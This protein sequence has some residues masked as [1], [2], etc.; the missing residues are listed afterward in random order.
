MFFGKKVII[1]EGGGF[2]TSFT[3][4]VL[5]AFMVYDQFDFDVIV[6]VSGGALAGSYFLSRQFGDYYNTI[7]DY[8]KDPRFV[9]FSKVF[10]EGLLNLNF[11]HEITEQNFP[12]NKE[13][14]V[15][16]LSVKS[17][18][19]VLTHANTG[20]AHYLQPNSENWIDMSIATCT[21]P[22]LTKGSHLVGQELYS[23]GGISDPIPIKWVMQQ[24][25]SEVL[26]IRTTDA[27]FKISAVKPEFFVSKMIKANNNIKKSVNNYQEN[28][29]ESVD[30]ANSLQKE[31]R[32]EQIIP[33]KALKTQLYTNSIE[34]IVRDYRNG[35]EAGMNFIQKTKK[36]KR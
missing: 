11:F 7:K 1:L 30:Y 16:S 26:L 27:K 29:K 10:S 4:G 34:N 15:N 6:G 13:L 36:I 18:F 17:F 2:K 24:N 8:C 9:S 32:I 5:D 14:A 35:I 28:I 25:P 22:L 19:I 33:D 31:G 20:K 12:L 21:V 3:A 23:D